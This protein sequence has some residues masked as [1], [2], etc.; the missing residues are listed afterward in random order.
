MCPPSAGASSSTTSIDSL[1]QAEKGDKGGLS[2]T[3]NEWK[4]SHPKKRGDKNLRIDIK[5]DFKDLYQELAVSTEYSNVWG[6]TSQSRSPDGGE[7]M[8]RFPMPTIE[9]KLVDQSSKGRLPACSLRNVEETLNPELN[10]QN[11]N[12]K[13][14]TNK[15]KS[16]RKKGKSAGMEP[17]GTGQTSNPYSMGFQDGS[18]ELL[19]SPGNFSKQKKALPN[20]T[21]KDLVHKSLQLDNPT[22]YL[23]IGGLC[24]LKDSIIPFLK[25]SEHDSNSIEESLSE[26]F[27][28]LHEAALK[29]G[30]SEG[31]RRVGSWYVNFIHQTVHASWQ[32]DQHQCP[33]S[34][35]D[36]LNKLSVGEIFPVFYRAKYKEWVDLVKDIR[37]LKSDEYEKLT[38]IMPP[39][40]IEDRK[41][42]MLANSQ[43]KS[44]SKLWSAIELQEM[45]SQGASVPRLLHI[46]YILDLGCKNLRWKNSEPETM[47]K[48]AKELL[49]AMQGYILGF[50]VAGY[51]GL[52]DLTWV[53]SLERHIIMSDTRLAKKFEACLA[54][55]AKH[56]NKIACVHETSEE[57]YNTAENSS[58]LDT[59]EEI[60]DLKGEVGQGPKG[61]KKEIDIVKDQRMEFEY[62]GKVKMV[63]LESNPSGTSVLFQEKQVT[64]GDLLLGVH[65]GLNYQYLVAL[66]TYIMNSNLLWI[67]SSTSHL[68]KPT[69][70][71]LESQK[72]EVITQRYT[73]ICQFW[74]SNQTH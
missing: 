2:P 72:F 62:G 47:H 39:V 50:P 7:N 43:F 11:I 30:V 45:S 74:E 57:Q 58:K 46:V 52:S 5:N 15:K 34:V 31:K 69:I 60:G 27:L 44:S 9:E 29:L 38:S 54:I 48:K 24:S 22:P 3:E 20:L 41:L 10:P 59:T 6:N 55:L 35:R 21:K 71:F 64:L 14:R 73:W 13:E 56:A 63:E 23:R 32:R 65:F 18:C 53:D 12:I 42:C 61:K 16:R 1:V 33:K 4:I 28:C 17:L 67:E 40:E 8:K 19:T 70:D 37:S 66:K 36:I 26:A 51:R 25:D 49:K 68:Q